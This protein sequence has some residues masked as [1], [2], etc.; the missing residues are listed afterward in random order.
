MEACWLESLHSDLSEM[1]FEFDW[2]R[3]VAVHDIMGMGPKYQPQHLTSLVMEVRCAADTDRATALMSEFS[4]VLSLVIYA[5]G[6]TVESSV[7]WMKAGAAHVSTSAA[8]VNEFL[9]AFGLNQ[10]ATSEPESALIGKSRAIQKLQADI[11]LVANRRCNVLIEGETGTGKEVAAREIHRAGDRH[12]GPWVPVNCGAIPE[13]LLEAELFGHVKGAFTGAIQTRMGKFEAAN[14]GTIFLDEIADM[15]L[16]VQVKLLRV[17]QE[18]E[19][20]RLG[21]NERI[22]LN[23]RVIAATNAS[24]DERVRQG[25]FREDLYYRLNVIRIVVPPLRARTEDIPLLAR[26][27]VQKVCGQ[28]NMPPK[29]LDGSTIERLVARNW[30]GNIR[31]LENVIESALIVSAD[32]S[33]I[34]PADLGAHNSPPQM[35]REPSPATQSLPPQGLDYQSALEEFESNLLTQALTTARGNKSAAAD[36]LGLKRTTLAAKMKVLGTRITGAAA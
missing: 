7:R 20:V 15:P 26:H 33:I 27:F 25:L 34:F 18:R 13:P 30:N 17:L 19:V 31:E 4:G 16:A 14:Q 1:P 8:D 10:A 32:R 5:P 23:V 3:T 22:K 36:L 35:M 21:G 12:R 6:I 11:R 2:L 9:S 29:A 28:E 24:L